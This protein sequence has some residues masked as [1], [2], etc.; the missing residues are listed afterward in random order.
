MNYRDLRQ[1]DSSGV[2]QTCSLIDKV[3]DHLERSEDPEA[4]DFIDIMEKIR[5]ANT[6]LREH[7]AQLNWGFT[8]EVEELRDESGK[9]TDEIA[10]LED[11]IRGLED[12]IRNYESQTSL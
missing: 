9:K 5:T 1:W 4:N 12:D 11:K 6:E 8:D 10:D 7:G 3:I 2:P